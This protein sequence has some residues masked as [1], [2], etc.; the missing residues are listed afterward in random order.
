MGKNKESIS[1][2]DEDGVVCESCILCDIHK[3]K[4]FI[5]MVFGNGHLVPDSGKFIYWLFP[6]MVESGEGKIC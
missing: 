1:S 2:L 3:R 6:E 5:K 4:D